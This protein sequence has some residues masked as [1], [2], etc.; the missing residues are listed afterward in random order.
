VLCLEELADV[1]IY[2]IGLLLVALPWT[3]ASVP[4]LAGAAPA[5]QSDVKQTVVKT[6]RTFFHAYDRADVRGVMQVVGVNIGIGDCDYAHHRMLLL[7]RDQL[8]A[9]LR[10]RFRQHDRMQGKVGTALI[11][12]GSGGPVVEIEVVRHNDILDSLLRAGVVDQIGFKIILNSHGTRIQWIAMSSPTVCQAGTVPPGAKPDAE[13]RLARSYLAAYNAHQLNAVLDL[14][15]PAVIYEDCD[16]TVGTRRTLSGPDAVAAWLRTLFAAGD[17]FVSPQ[18]LVD[19]WYSEPPNDPTTVV[20]RTTRS[21]RQA[22]GA[23]DRQS[24]LILS[25]TTD[26]AHIQSWSDQGTCVQGRDQNG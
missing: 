22:V 13:I 16:Y 15:D 1:K 2:R 25:P 20:I 8:P 9:W 26:G 19:S 14:L 3:W 7:Y 12:V 17:Q 21:Q 5:P 23:V 10:K 6:L 4:S 11:G 18:I 24:V